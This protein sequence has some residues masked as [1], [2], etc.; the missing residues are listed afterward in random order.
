MTNKMV[1]PDMT[2]IMINYA[3][4]AEWRI[5]A[6]KANTGGRGFD[7]AKQINDHAENGCNKISYSCLVPGLLVLHAPKSY[8]KALKKYYGHDIRPVRANRLNLERAIFA[9][10]NR[11]GLAID[12]RY[13][14]FEVAMML[15]PSSQ[16]V[17]IEIGCTPSL[18]A[19]LYKEFYHKTA[20]SSNG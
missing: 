16:N 17:V 11:F 8:L 1:Q 20:Y 13:L 6:N 14:D 3:N 12:M 15:A 19:G 4:S 10:A 9:N 5:S 7:I 2:A 18:R